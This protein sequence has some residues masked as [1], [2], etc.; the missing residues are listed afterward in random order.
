ML[1]LVLALDRTR[2][3]PDDVTNKNSTLRR[4]W[5][6]AVM[7]AMSVLCRN[8]GLIRRP[9]LLAAMAVAP[10]LFPRLPPTTAAAI[11]DVAS[12]VAL[13]VSR[14]LAMVMVVLGVD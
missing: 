9:S 6:I 1:A 10:P 5:T 7:G 8:G 2:A 14:L 3:L 4:G 11:R 12:T 13:T